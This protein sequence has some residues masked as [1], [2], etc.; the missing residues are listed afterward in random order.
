MDRIRMIG[1]DMSSTFSISARR[2]SS[3]ISLYGLP[4]LAAARSMASDS[5][6]DSAKSGAIRQP[7]S[8]SPSASRLERLASATSTRTPQS[9]PS[10]GYAVAGRLAKGAW[11]QKLLPAPG[12]LSTPISPPIISISR[13]EIARPNP[14]PPCFRALEPST[15]EKD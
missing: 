12:A 7:A 13:F 15:C 3:R 11:N 2:R 8:S 1:V 4:P 9:A 5:L 10:A 6:L 14:V